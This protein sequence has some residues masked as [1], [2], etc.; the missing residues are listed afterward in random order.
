MSTRSP[1][2]P[3]L[4]SRGV[5]I[6]D[7]RA[8]IH[9]IAVAELAEEFGTPLFVYDA[10][11]IRA[12]V[13][14]AVQATEWQVAYASKAFLCRELA[15]MMDSLGVH[16]D[17]A[18]G[19]ELHVALSAGFDPARIVFHGNNKSEAEIEYGVAAGV[20]LFV[21]DSLA[22]IARLERAAKAAGRRQPVLVRVTP[23]VEAHT[24]E[25]IMTGQE[26]SK[27]GFSVTSGAAEEALRAVRSSSWLDFQGIHAHI[28]SQIFLLDSYAKEVDA[29]AVLVQEHSPRILNLGGG[30]GVA[31]VAGE[32]NPGFDAWATQLFAALE[33]NGIDREVR[34]MVEPGRSLVAQ[35]A[36]TVYRVGTIKRL[37]GLRTY[38]SVDG[39]MSD[40]PRPVL[41]GSG[42]EAFMP[43]AADAERDQIATVVGKHCE[44]GDV[45][46]RDAWLPSS[47]AE[48]DLLAT[49]VTGA[50]GYSMASNYNRVPRPPVVF[51]D[52]EGARLAVRG[53]SFEDMVR[54]D[55]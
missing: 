36:M 20:G 44:S 42:Y 53:E 35:S 9:R 6:R 46:I 45:L 26:D 17:V 10:E 27:F 33:R 48:G 28:G 52:R 43:E 1:I 34:V 41:Y 19:G 51:V 31:Y 5:S 47:L 25:Y 50:Y 37:E 15:R 23:G 4:L 40:N 2:S 16:M 14:A 49:P 55:L 39:G 21:I 54:L 12:E 13:T 3:R 30:L 22:E 29:L 18:S 24:H 38:V 11:H 32:E 8:F 7:G